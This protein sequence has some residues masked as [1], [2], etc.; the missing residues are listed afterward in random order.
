MIFDVEQKVTHSGV[1]NLPASPIEEALLSD[2]EGALLS[3][4]K[5]I[6][7]TIRIQPSGDHPVANRGVHGLAT[8]YF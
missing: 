5:I 8:W 6:Y 3:R 4:P 2:H 1:Y 7:R